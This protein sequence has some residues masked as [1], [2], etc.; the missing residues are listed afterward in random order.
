M[1]PQ[2]TPRQ[3]RPAFFG[4]L[5]RVWLER[6][7]NIL[8]DPSALR[9]RHTLCVKGGTVTAVLARRGSSTPVARG[10]ACD[11]A[12]LNLA[13]PSVAWAYGL[14]YTAMGLRA[15]GR[16]MN[17]WRILAHI[18]GTVDQ[19]LLLRNEYLAAENRILKIR[20][21]GRVK[22]SDAERATLA[23][24]GQR[25]GR[26]PSTRWRQ[27]PDRTPSWP[28]TEGWSPANSMDHSPVEPRGDRQLTEMLSN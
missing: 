17:W 9:R 18:T 22:L 6:D 14:S 21:E 26:R 24:I 12:G 8:T 3:G 10:E 23:E 7:S 5:G 25:L 16:L 1:E 2:P 27:S 4:G 19:E 28:G 11:L 20:L 15:A 13:R